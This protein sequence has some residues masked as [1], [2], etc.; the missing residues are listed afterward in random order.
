MSDEVETKQQKVDRVSKGV[1]S[2]LQE[3][4]CILRT[5]VI[6]EGGSVI[7]KAF[8]DLAPEPEA[9]PEAQ[10]ETASK[11]NEDDIPDGQ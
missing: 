2:Y 5:Q 1:Q 8:I 4:G 10:P 9:Q 7:S 6:I 11:T 3:N